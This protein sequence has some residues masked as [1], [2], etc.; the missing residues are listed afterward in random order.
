[1]GNADHDPAHDFSGYRTFSW[2]SEHPMKVGPVI[3]DPRDHIEPAI[4]DSIRSNLEGKG[5]D[6]VGD[7]DSADF[8]VSFTVGSREKVRPSGYPTMESQSGGR[9]SWGT[10]YHHGEEGATYNQ[11]VLAIDV[12]D[13]DERR[14]VWHGVT[15]KRIDDS[16]REDMSELINSVVKSLLGNFPP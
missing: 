7:P 12:F 4:M 2:I 1:V 9:W 8:V 6:F 5:F 13:T 3:S 16:G 10:E 11:G 15:G 14:P